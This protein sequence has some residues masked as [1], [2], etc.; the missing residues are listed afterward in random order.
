MIDVE[1]NIVWPQ[2]LQR[3]AAQ[4]GVFSG[5]TQSDLM[6]RYKLRMIEAARKLRIPI[7]NI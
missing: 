1:S 4:R 3:R 7:A 6:R 5:N 2:Q